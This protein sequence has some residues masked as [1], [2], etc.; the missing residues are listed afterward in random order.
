MKNKLQKEAEYIIGPIRVLPGR[1]SVSRTF[2]DV[3]AKMDFK[4]GN[5]NVVKAEPEIVQF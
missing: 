5:M 4:G 3:E 2:G 1:L